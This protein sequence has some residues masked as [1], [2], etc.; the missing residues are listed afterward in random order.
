[1]PIGTVSGSG[2][3]GPACVPH[4]T[5]H[6]ASRVPAAGFP[7]AASRECAGHPELDTRRS[8]DVNALPPLVARV[9][10]LICR[11]NP[12]GVVV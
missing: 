7:A 10:L 12:F 9:A 3:D 5:A 11:S 1:M 8:Q 6:R 2:A 4:T